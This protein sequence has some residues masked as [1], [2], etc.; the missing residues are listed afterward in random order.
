[1]D[2]VS[3]AIRRHTESSQGAHNGNHTPR[4]VSPHLDDH[5]IVRGRRKH[6]SRF[7]LSNV[8]HAIRDAMP[9]LT[10]SRESSRDRGHG[11]RGRTLD[12]RP[13][14][15][16][17]NST[18]HHNDQDNGKSKAKHH[19]THLLNKVGEMLKHDNAEHKTEA[20]DWKE[21]KKG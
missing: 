4:T 19:N 3:E 11:A 18:S 21:F 17:L 13:L 10:R 8:S 2:G 14:E 1:M 12:I 5:E 15:P 7:T 16:I 20:S 9:I 6:H